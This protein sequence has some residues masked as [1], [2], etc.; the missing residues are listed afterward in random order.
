MTGRV[1]RLPGFCVDKNGKIVRGTAHHGVSARIRQRQSKRA[2]V[3][4]DCAMVAARSQLLAWRTRPPYHSPAVP[5]SGAGTGP[6][7]G[8]CHGRLS[9]SSS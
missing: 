4:N 3:V 9:L 2:K 5:A 7:R 8:D 6:P 1:I